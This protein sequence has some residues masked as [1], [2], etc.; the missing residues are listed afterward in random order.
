M[1]EFRVE[2]V[3][4]LSNMKCNW[5]K[6]NSQIIVEKIKNSQECR[7]CC[8]RKDNR[9]FNNLSFRNILKFNS[10]SSLI[11]GYEKNNFEWFLNFKNKWRSKYNLSFF[12][13]CSFV[14]VFALSTVLC[15][16]VR[17]WK[18]RNLWNIMKI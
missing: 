16:I 17:P 5:N 9:R 2:I 1:K 18:K 12:P 13:S 15:F 14:Y 10:I 8:W 11:V 6:N 3:F 7:K 4:I